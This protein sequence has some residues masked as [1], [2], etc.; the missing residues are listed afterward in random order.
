MKLLLP[1][2]SAPEI[3]LLPSG[4]KL[5]AGTTLTGFLSTPDGSG[6]KLVIANGLHARYALASRYELDGESVLVSLQFENGLLRWVEISIAAAAGASWANWSAADEARK[7]TRH[8]EIVRKEYGAEPHT[9][10]WGQAG[11]Y[12]DPRGGGSSII[13]RFR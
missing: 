10:P 7:H 5:G 2:T 12:E 6:S 13:V 3:T 8:A 9:A 1:Q 4:T 11:A